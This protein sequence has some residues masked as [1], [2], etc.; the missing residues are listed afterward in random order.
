MKYKETNVPE[1]S[2]KPTSSIA[3]YVAGSIAALIAVASLIN[4]IVLFNNTVNDYVDQGYTA[5]D[6]IKHFIPV[7][8]LPGIF[9]PIAVYGGIALVLIYAGLIYQKVSKCENLLTEVEVCNNV[10]EGGFMESIKDVENIETTKGEEINIED[11]Q[12]AD[13]D[14]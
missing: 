12:A 9:E 2:K 10:I 14:K 13:E 1:K 5:A 8:L 7:Q 3:L 6:V 4:N 11:N